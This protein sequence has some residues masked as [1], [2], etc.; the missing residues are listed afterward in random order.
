M[1]RA[2]FPSPSKQNQLLSWKIKL[3][4]MH[5]E[6]NEIQLQCCLPPGPDDIYQQLMEHVVRSSS[7]VFLG[8]NAQRE[9]AL[10]S[11]SS[12]R[13]QPICLFQTLRLLFWL[14]QLDEEMR[15][16]CQARQSPHAGQLLGTH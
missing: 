5:S 7:P 4:T 8:H 10:Q 2:T 6:H 12:A 3:Q 1:L 16:L 11:S 9:A 13:A 15:A 14:L